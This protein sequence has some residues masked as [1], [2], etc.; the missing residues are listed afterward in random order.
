[1]VTWTDSSSA[2]VME[3]V[4]REALKDISEVCYSRAVCDYHTVARHYQHSGYLEARH[5]LGCHEALAVFSVGDL[6]GFPPY[7]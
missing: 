6:R 1:M 2:V 5:L 3:P 7:V 4:C